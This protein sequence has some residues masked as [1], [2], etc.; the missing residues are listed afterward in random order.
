LKNLKRKAGD[1]F[2]PRNDAELNKQ[3]HHII[4][5]DVAV[6]DLELLFFYDVESL[7]EVEFFGGIEPIYR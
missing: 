2:V 3:L 1:C 7:F 5:H 4:V 6:S